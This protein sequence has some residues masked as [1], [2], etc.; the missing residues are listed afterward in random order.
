MFCFPLHSVVWRIRFHCTEFNWHVYR[1]RVGLRFS[2]KV[3]TPIPYNYRLII[4]VGTV[5]NIKFL[6]TVESEHFIVTVVKVKWGGFS[7]LKKTVWGQAT[8]LKL[9]QQFGFIK[10]VDKNA[11]PQF[12][13]KLEIH[14]LS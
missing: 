8:I 4:C 11:A 2:Y 1:V 12:L 3:S 13:K 9:K 7:C 5:N 10:R 14:L 6:F